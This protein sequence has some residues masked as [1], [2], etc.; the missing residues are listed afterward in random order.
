MPFILSPN[1]SKFFNKKEISKKERLHGDGITFDINSPEAL[2]EFFFNN[3]EDFIKRELLN[4]L[5][6]RKIDINHEKNI[7]NLVEWFYKKK[8]YK[9]I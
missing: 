9:I 3:N 6:L 8:I 2:D 7:T 5:K 4:Y 1:I